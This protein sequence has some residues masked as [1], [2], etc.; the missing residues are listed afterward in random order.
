VEEKKEKA[1]TR[2]K[3][4]RGSKVLIE[5]AKACSLAEDCK[6]G[7]EGG[8]AETAR[9][10]GVVAACGRSLLKLGGRL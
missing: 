1:R 3:L 7:I 2:S 8:K 10:S 6:G 9:G 4:V 5:S